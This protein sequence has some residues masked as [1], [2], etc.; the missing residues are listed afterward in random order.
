MYEV[1]TRGGR[2]AMTTKQG[3]YSVARLDALAFLTEGIARS[4]P[5]H[6]L[7]RNLYA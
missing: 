6:Q 3:L 7:M 4:S 2:G 5:G 1:G